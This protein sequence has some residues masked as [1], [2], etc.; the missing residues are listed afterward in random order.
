[1]TVS[2]H[3][4]PMRFYLTPPGGFRPAV[5]VET[6][7]VVNEAAIEQLRSD[8]HGLRCPS[9]ILFDESWCVILRDTFEQ[10]DESS[11]IEDGRLPTQEVLDRVVA[12]GRSL[13]ERVE[14]WL[15][16]LSANWDEALPREPELA[17]HFIPD[18]VP[19]ASGSMVWAVSSAARAGQ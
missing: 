16:V 10:M 3:T 9:G 12:K 17:K 1:M 5:V 8:L 18:I 13:D 19:A 7:P 4:L 2:C 14:R 15:D 6:H 11:I